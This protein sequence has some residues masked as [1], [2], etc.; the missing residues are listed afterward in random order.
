MS[1][2]ALSLP[3]APADERV[4]GH[5]GLSP[6]R[7]AGVPLGMGLGPVAV[8]ADERGRGVAAQLIREGLR[9]CREAHVGLV[10]VLGDPRYYSRFGFVPARQLSLQDEYGGG[11]AFQ[12]L[13]LVS[14]AVPAAGGLVQYSPVFAQLGV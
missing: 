11:D 7:V 12:A 3:P 2:V 1:L 8:L 4:I 14:G 5:V 9:W 6:I 13:E 10:V